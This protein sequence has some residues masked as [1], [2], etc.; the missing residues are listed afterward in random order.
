MP[1]PSP[2][3]RHPLVMPDGQPH[4]STVFL[5]AAI[6]HPRWMVGDYSYASAHE[7]PDDWAMNLSPYLYPQSPELLKIGKFVQIADGVKFITAS[8]NHRY[9]GISSY[10]F[11]IFDG[12]DGSRP[13]LPDGPYPD[14]I[15]GNDVWI[16]QGARIL[17][18]C[19]IGSGVI[20]GAGAVVGGNIPDYAVIVGNPGEI[21]RMRFEKTTISSLLDCSWWDWPIDAILANET[22]ICGADID[23]LAKADR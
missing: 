6:D 13:S 4:K 7:P 1:F 10:P 18:G 12:M 16:G 23:L 8:A 21:V 11:A 19:V 3:T 5:S 2:E 22:A 9:D 17:P 20:I 14:T 15:I